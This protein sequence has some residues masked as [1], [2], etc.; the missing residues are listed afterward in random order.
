MTGATGQP[1]QREGVLAHV[2]ALLLLVVAAIRELDQEPVIASGCLTVLFAVL[3]LVG[4]HWG[5]GWARRVTLGWA[6]VSCSV[7]LA[8][9]L[10]WGSDFV[11]AS[12]L[13]L[14]VLTV[15]L[16]FSGPLSV[17]LLG[18][19]GLALATRM[20]A[21]EAVAQVGFVVAL[22]GIIAVLE[23]MRRL[24]DVAAQAR[25]QVIGLQVNAEHERLTT[26]LNAVIGSTLRRAQ[27]RVVTV[28]GLLHAADPQTK[29]QY[30]AV[31]GVL[32]DGLRTLEGL[33]TTFAVVDVDAELV[34]ANELCQRLGARLTKDVTV[35]KDRRVEQLAALVIREAVT[36][37]FKHARPSRIVIV[38]RA[39]EAETIIAVTNDG[40]HQDDS[41][42][43]SGGTG[44]A[45]WRDD[46]QALGGSVV[47]GGLAGHR[48]HVLVRLPCPLHAG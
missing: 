7:G 23:T 47:T 37:A 8:A 14:L 31:V 27:T 24:L 15:R 36:N 45:R 4:L 35:P 9:I 11:A 39:D 17:A 34:T 48:Y 10:L 42:L 28:A 1:N 16:R 18:T 41:V 32:E 38:V 12:G 29:Q 21:S 44:Q 43:P 22:F 20:P 6:G 30:D 26:I 3:A 40:T 46:A 19:D 13:L 25:G 2:L 33:T 5:Q